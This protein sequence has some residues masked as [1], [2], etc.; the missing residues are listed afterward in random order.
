M[1]NVFFYFLGELKEKSLS[2]YHLYS[3]I[4][5]SSIHLFKYMH[6]YVYMCIYMCI[7]LHIYMY[8]I[9]LSSKILFKN[10]W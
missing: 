3:S 10:I 1:Y 6:I 4:Y 5:L 7:S 2:L 9:H 8:L